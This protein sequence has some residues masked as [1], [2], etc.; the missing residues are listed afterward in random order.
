MTETDFN[1]L[2]RNVC[3]R[4]NQQIKE[5][6]IAFLNDRN[7]F[8]R[9]EFETEVSGF[10]LEFLHR[11]Q[12]IIVKNVSISDEF[13]IFEVKNPYISEWRKCKIKL[14]KVDPN[15]LHLVSGCIIDKLRCQ[16][17]PKKVILV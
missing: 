3:N 5:T 9:E 6:L 17:K 11:D 13:M 14:D 12:T 8:N 10:I 2:L 15:K 4:Y 7:R 1:L 16:K